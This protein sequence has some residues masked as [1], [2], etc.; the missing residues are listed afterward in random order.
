MSVSTPTTIFAFLPVPDEPVVDW[1]A[2]S[3][4]RIADVESPSKV[5]SPMKRRRLIRPSRSARVSESTSLMRIPPVLCPHGM[6]TRRAP[7]PP[8]NLLCGGDD[9]AGQLRH[10]LLGEAEGRAGDADCARDAQAVV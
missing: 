2:S 1:H 4:A 3:S 5:A 9:V 10:P 8:R 7:E 6:W